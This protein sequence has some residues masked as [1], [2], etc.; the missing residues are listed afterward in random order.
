[1]LLSPS[2]R[3]L[4]IEALESEG[5]SASG[6]FVGGIEFDLTENIG[7]GITTE[8]T[9]DT[10]VLFLLGLNLRVLRVPRGI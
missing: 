10:E 9:G 4:C 8:D 6:V 2:S 5:A 7:L 1:M 3:R